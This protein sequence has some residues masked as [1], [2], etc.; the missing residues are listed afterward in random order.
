MN[1]D[2]N[3]QSRHYFSLQPGEKA[4]F[5]AADGVEPLVIGERKQDV[6]PPLLPPRKARLGKASR[7]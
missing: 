2:Q 5:E 3:K 1:P 7:K 4:V 6:G